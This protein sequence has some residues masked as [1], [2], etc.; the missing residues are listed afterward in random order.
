[1]KKLYNGFLIFVK[2]VLLVI[3]LLFEIII[4]YFSFYILMSDFGD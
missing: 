3:G 2:L 4:F 1:M